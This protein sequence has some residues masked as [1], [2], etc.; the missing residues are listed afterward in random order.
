MSSRH[1]AA[2]AAVSAAR[3]QQMQQSASKLRAMYS[4]PVSSVKDPGFEMEQSAIAKELYQLTVVEGVPDK[5]Q[6]PEEVFVG[7]FLRVFRDPDS[8]DKATREKVLGEWI[9]VAG[10]PMFEADVVDYAGNVL[11]TVPAFH[12]TE[13]INAARD[14]GAPSYADIAAM[15]QMLQN[16]AAGRSIDY[17]NDSFAKKMDSAK[18]GMKQMLNKQ[19]IWDAIFERYKDVKFESEDIKEDNNPVVDNDEDD[20]IYD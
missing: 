3:Q 4:K 8:V 11:F 9:A 15:A 2:L 1:E 18:K 16:Q 7:Y 14:P 17:Q 19:P 12:N 13:V 6:V 20:I 5:R 10:G